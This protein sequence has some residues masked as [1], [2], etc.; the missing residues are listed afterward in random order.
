MGGEEVKFLRFAEVI[1]CAI[2]LLSCTDPS[3]PVSPAWIIPGE[4]V[5]GVRLRDRLETVNSK[6]G[7]FTICCSA[8]GYN[9]KA[10]YF[11]ELVEGPLAGLHVYFIDMNY[12]GQT[13]EPGP[14][15]MIVLEEPYSGKTEEGFGI[16]TLSSELVD[17]WGEPDLRSTDSLGPDFHYCFGTS[18][19]TFRIKDDRVAAITIGVLFPTAIDSALW[20]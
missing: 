12:L 8:E 9:T 19:C 7:E 17:A 1:P 16:G 10:W 2:L 5:N 11:A 13:S 18:A 14:V 4:S 6:L 15:D 20:R 3:E